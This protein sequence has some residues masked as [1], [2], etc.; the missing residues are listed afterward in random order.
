MK[1]EKAKINKKKEMTGVVI[2]NKMTGTVRVKVADVHR[3]PVYSK[4]IR[5][6]KVYFAHTDEN[7]N[8]G[9]NVTIRETKPYSKNVTWAVI[10]KK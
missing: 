8:I 10:S 9:D 1:E 7:L 6:S 5:Q 4:V 2:S 3:D